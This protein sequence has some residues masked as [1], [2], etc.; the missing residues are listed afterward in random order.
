MRHEHNILVEKLEG[1]TPLDRYK[2]RWEDNIKIVLKEIGC[3]L[4]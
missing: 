4:I 2:R 1:K 3:G